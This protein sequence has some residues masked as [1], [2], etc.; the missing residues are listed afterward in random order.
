MWSLV[1]EICGAAAFM[2]SL[3]MILMWGYILEGVMQ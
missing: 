1:K 3:Y 2:L